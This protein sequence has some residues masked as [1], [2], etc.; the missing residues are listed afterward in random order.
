MAKPDASV[1][2]QCEKLL[3]SAKSGELQG[4]AYVGYKG[5][6]KSKFT[7]GYYALTQTEAMMAPAILGS[8]V[9]QQFFDTTE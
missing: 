2:E 5:A 8:V 4:I 7:M 3:A 9:S 6:K 1:I